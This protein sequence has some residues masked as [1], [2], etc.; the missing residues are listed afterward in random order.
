MPGSKLTFYLV[1]TTTKAA[2]YTDAACTIA[3][4]NPVI[5]DNNGEFAAIYLNADRD[6]LLTTSA[7]AAMW[8][9]IQVNASIPLDIAVGFTSTYT[10]NEELARITLTR[11]CIFPANML[12]SK[13]SAGT[14]PAS[15]SVTFSLKKNGV[16]FATAAFAAAATTC[17]F[18]GSETTFAAGDYLTLVAPAGVNS[19]LVNVGISLKGTR[20]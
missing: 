9:P 8:G 14:G 2:I 4:A 3:H 5:A 16:E 7:D 20:T 17:T 1:A 19:A 11:G 13:G 18:S 6:V 15:T 12:D 10:S